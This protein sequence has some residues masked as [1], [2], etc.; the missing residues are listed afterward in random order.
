VIN[1]NK[2]YSEEKI[3]EA[4]ENHEFIFLTDIVIFELFAWFILE[5][6]DP[7]LTLE[8]I[9]LIFK[10]YCRPIY[11]PG[12]NVN[13][14]CTVNYPSLSV[15]KGFIAGGKSRKGLYTCREFD[16]YNTIGRKLTM[17]HL[18]TQYYQNYSCVESKVSKIVNIGSV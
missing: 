17:D 8:N 1:A 15:N 5:K 7:S 2:S 16:K 4:I 10:G 13:R 6:V 18:K 3:E 9:R 14:Q 11:I 12:K